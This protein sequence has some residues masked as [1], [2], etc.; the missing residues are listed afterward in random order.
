[1][2]KNDK[3]GIR[4]HIHMILPIEPMEVLPPGGQVSA[5]YRS[6][7]RRSSGYDKLR[8]KVTVGAWLCWNTQYQSDIGILTRNWKMPL[9]CFLRVISKKRNNKFI[10]NARPYS[11]FH[12]LLKSDAKHPA[13]CH[14]ADE[15]RKL[16]KSQAQPDGTKVHGII[17]NE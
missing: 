1:M 10:C 15:V 2:L 7:R 11:E 4:C 6:S 5:G 3:Q 17:L 8:R 9:N 12:G 16:V 13:A 14:G